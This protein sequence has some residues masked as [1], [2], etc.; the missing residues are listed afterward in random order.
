M[1]LRASPFFIL[2]IYSLLLSGC[3]MGM[4]GMDHGPSHQMPG[5]ARTIEKDVPEQDTRLSL[6]V[7]PLSAGNEATLVLTAARIQSNAPLTNARVTFT[8]G[9]A[10]QAGVEPA[11]GHIPEADEREAEEIPRKGVYQL[12]YKFEEQGLYRITARVR[13]G[14]ASPMTITLAQ[15][16]GGEVHAEESMMPWMIIGGIGMA[17]MMLFMA[18]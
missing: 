3:M 12:R 1:G 16:A 14:T 15:N 8:I 2:G 18:F 7:P 9:R 17:V 13:T 11:D 6:D 10:P 4:H 5:Q